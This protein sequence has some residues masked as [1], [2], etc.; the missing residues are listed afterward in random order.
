MKSP[1]VKTS[2]NNTGGPRQVHFK[3]GSSHSSGSSF[4]IT[5]GPDTST[6]STAST[7][8]ASDNHEDEESVPGVFLHTSSN[9]SASVNLGYNFPPSTPFGQVPPQ[10]TYGPFI[11]QT[12]THPAFAAEANAFAP[13]GK[14]NPF[15]LQAPAYVNMA[16]YQNVAPP[17]GG[18]HFQPPVP[19][20]SHGVMQHVYVPRFDNGAPPHPGYAYHVGPPQ[21]QILPLATTTLVA[22]QPAPV[23]LNAPLVLYYY[24]S[25][26]TFTYLKTLIS[27]GAESQVVFGMCLFARNLLLVINSF[28]LANS[29]TKLY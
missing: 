19:D 5:Q 26:H 3:E 8:P 27:I 28:C 2:A 17:A 1:K 9:P 4:P 6:T 10:P 24:A 21:V 13:F 22:Q 25:H 15:G 12:S 14:F 7:A 16:D 23:L 18:L 11:P 29:Q 20:T